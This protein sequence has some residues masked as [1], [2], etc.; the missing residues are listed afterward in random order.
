MKGEDLHELNINE[1]QQLEKT[2][3]GGLSRVIEEKVWVE[4]HTS[5]LRET[6]WS[7]KSQVIVYVRTISLLDPQLYFINV[8][9]YCL[10]LNE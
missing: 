5:W 4:S 10:R 9:N 8:R 6:S 7:R 3:E 1:L 2:I